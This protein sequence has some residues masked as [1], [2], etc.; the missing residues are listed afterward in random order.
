MSLRT[1]KHL[2]RQSVPALYKVMQSAKKQAHDKKND[3]IAH[4]VLPFAKQFVDKNGWQIMHGPF[5]GLQYH[6][7]TTERFDLTRL[8][9][10]YEAEIHPFTTAAHHR[11]YRLR[12]RP[13][14]RRLRQ[15][16][17]HCNSLC[18]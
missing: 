6:K 10:C 4:S 9:G 15:A 8:I 1:L 13:C 5:R 12:A 16:L 18:L 11:R 17:P 3:Q 2:A 7:A 14:G